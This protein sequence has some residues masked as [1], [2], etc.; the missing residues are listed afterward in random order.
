M[1][2]SNLQVQKGIKIKDQKSKIKNQDFVPAES[3]ACLKFF[4]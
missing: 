4:E 3:P 1:K 2:R